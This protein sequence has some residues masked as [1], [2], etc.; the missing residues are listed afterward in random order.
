V[1]PV[2]AALFAAILREAGT[3]GKSWVYGGQRISMQNLGH[4][5]GRSPST[6]RRRSRPRR[7]LP[8]GSLPPALDRERFAAELGGIVKVA[9]TGELEVGN[10]APFVDAGGGD[11][12]KGAAARRFA[13]DAA[14]S[15]SGLR[16]ERAGS[17]ASPRWASGH[18][19]T[20]VSVAQ[21]R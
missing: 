18:P 3:V 6:T 5:L 4:G 16:G 17:I 9:A 12:G 10:L 19:R 15:R 20:R 8:A 21:T 2:E 11:S 14:E 1:T 7:V 13:R